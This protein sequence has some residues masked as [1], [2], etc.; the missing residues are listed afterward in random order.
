MSKPTHPATVN[1]DID[2]GKP[3]AH[4]DSDPRDQAD[5]DRPFSVLILGDFSGHTTEHSAG[6]RP[7]HVD[8]DNFDDVLRGMNIRLNLHLGSSGKTLSMHFDDL[9]DFEPDGIYQRYEVFR[10]LGNVPSA[11]PTREVPTAGQG[12]VTPA[13]L[14]NLTGGSLLDNIV[15]ASESQRPTRPRPKD[16]LRQLVEKMTA[17]YVVPKE[18]EVTAYSAKRAEERAGILMRAILH[19]PDF[20]A[21]ESAWRAV[22]KLTRQLD[23]DK[24]LKVYLLD[25]SK[26]ELAENLIGLRDVVTRS[27]DER[28]AVLV[29][30]Y[31][32]DR[33]EAEI[34]LLM[35][36]GTLAQSAGAPFLA[37]SLPPDDSDQ[38]N[39]TWQGL[40]RSPCA[41]W[42]GLALPRFI[43]RQPYGASSY[44]AESFRFEEMPGLP[45]HNDYLWGNPA[46]ACVL[47]LGQS[48]SEYGW[49]FRPGTLHTI[50]NL[51]LHTYEVDGELQAQPCAEIL[52][53]ERE[54][55][56]IAG[57]GLIPLASIKRTDAIRVVR[58]QSIADPPAPLSGGWDYSYL[59]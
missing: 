23:T 43:L 25:I 52:M 24:N 54:A 53:T 7:V 10:N 56:Y 9:A 35:N 29:G 21:L 17:L 26:S 6:L 49:R 30:N 37:E 45:E 13:G 1:L 11:L 12:D 46:F 27:G 33:T 5:P 19:H 59:G 58:F 50:A 36:V 18:D 34:E 39:Q 8:R 15:E 42:I 55:D 51:P 22:W 44:G 20:Q 4:L 2:P 38:T 16:E 3:S 31:V 14:K 28:W 41:R 32:F 40:R 47:L 57:G 48:F